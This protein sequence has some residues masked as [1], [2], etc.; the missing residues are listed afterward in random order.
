[1]SIEVHVRLRPQDPTT[2]V[3]STADTVLYNV[4][5]PQTRY[6]FNKVH[7][8][9]NTTNKSVFGGVEPLVLAGFSSLQHVSIMAYGPTGSGKTYSMTGTREDAG[10]I[11]RTAKLLVKLA[12]THPGTL[13]KASFIEVYNECVRDLLDPGRGNGDLPLQDTPD[14]AVR[15]DKKVVSIESVS[16]FLSWQ[17]LAEQHRRYGVTDLNAH[18][19]RSHIMITFEVHRLRRVPVEDDGKRNEEEEEGGNGGEEL[20]RSASTVVHFVH[21]VDLAGAECAGKARTEGQALREGGCINK[22]LL[23][24]GNVVDALVERRSHVPYRDAKLTRLLRSALSGTGG[25]TFILCCIHPGKENVDQTTASLRFTQRAMRLKQDPVMVLPI[26]PLFTHQYANAVE[27]LLEASPQCAQLAYQRG[28]RDA[29]IYCDPTVANLTQQMQDEVGV[30]LHALAGMQRLLVARDHAISLDTIGRWY[31]KLQEVTMQLD[32]VAEQ[33]RSEQE[34]VRRFQ[35]QVQDKEAAIQAEEKALAMVQQKTDITLAEWEVQL[36]QLKQQRVTPLQL[37]LLKEEESRCRVVYEWCVC[38]ERIAN[39]SVEQYPLI[40]ILYQGGEVVEKPQESVG[41]SG[42]KEGEEHSLTAEEKKRNNRPSSFPFSVS[43]P[44][45][46]RENR[47]WEA[48]WQAQVKKERCAV[49]ELEAAKSL[50]HEREMVSMACTSPSE[51]DEKR[52]EGGRRIRTECHAT[53]GHDEEEEEHGAEEKEDRSVSFLPRLTDLDE[54]IDTLELEEKRLQ[55]LVLFNTHRYS[56]RRLRSSLS[57]YSLSFASETTP[58]GGGGSS[59]TAELQLP[60][61]VRR[62]MEGEVGSGREREGTPES[63]AISPVS[64]LPSPIASSFDRTRMPSRG[65]EQ[66]SEGTKGMWTRQTAPLL[67]V[68][69]STSSLHTTTRVEDG[70]AR[71]G[72][73]LIPSSPSA[74]TVTAAATSS[75]S[76]VL[77]VDSNPALTATPQEASTEAT[78]TILLPASRRISSPSPLP[79]SHPSR[80]KEREE[81][82]ITHRPV[83]LQRSSPCPSYRCPSAVTGVMAENS[84][85]GAMSSFQRRSP[86][87][88]TRQRS[89]SNSSSQGSRSPEGYLTP[90]MMRKKMARECDENSNLDS[91]VESSGRQKKRSM[92]SSRLDRVRRAPTSTDGATRKGGYSLVGSSP[93]SSYTSSSSSSVLHAQGLRTAT[94]T[95]QLIQELKSS[96]SQHTS[97]LARIGGASSSATPPPFSSSGAALSPGNTLRTPIHLHR[98]RSNSHSRSQL[99]P[100]N[101]EGGHGTSPFHLPCT[102]E[103]APS[104]GASSRRGVQRSGSSH[105]YRSNSN[106]TASAYGSSGP[107]WNSSTSVTGYSMPVSPGTPSPTSSFGNPFLSSYSA[108][109]LLR[110]E[111]EYVVSSVSKATTNGIPSTLNNIRS[112]TPQRRSGSSSSSSSTT[113]SILTRPPNHTR[114]PGM[115]ASQKSGTRCQEEEGRTTSYGNRSVNQTEWKRREKSVERVPREHEEKRPGYRRD[116]SQPSTARPQESLFGKGE[117]TVPK[118]TLSSYRSASPVSLGNENILMDPTDGV[119]EV[120]DRTPDAAAPCPGRMPLPPAHGRSSGHRSADVQRSPHYMTNTAMGGRGN[121]RVLNMSK[122]ITS[123]SNTPMKSEGGSSPLVK[124]AVNG[125]ARALWPSRSPSNS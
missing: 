42:G 23:A 94:H 71:D 77:P 110:R 104:P 68:S 36:H 39:E 103:E 55:R 1:M 53:E 84:I 7:P 4:A 11:I 43:L 101:E 125:I 59:Q 27:S 10:I 85:T 79:Y 76:G 61:T 16:D 114:L 99:F 111:G 41:G 25:Y 26:P 124:A 49:V 8:L 14:G 90:M 120:S 92:S 34:K 74:A 38:I 108:P 89:A 62:R 95:L 91:T 78:R 97:S 51:E 63:H 46:W 98:R 32:H 109:P 87:I 80:A 73:P 12:S 20:G 48:E 113:T 57:D 6:V 119:V 50:L 69:S 117:C 66:G 75:P 67:K 100:T 21:L 121:T 24:L 28:L 102:S 44:V 72:T 107:S 52:R 29:F 112:A 115:S 105:H 22:S 86:I 58:G 123:S 116:T 33:H 83:E 118:R 60:A 64:P 45:D 56:L 9:Q 2:V 17:Q 96:I 65:E 81:R 54:R 37:L 122:I 88:K 18:S 19:S 30:T 82:T 31:G 5:Q 70:K 47:A 13:L 93:P 40:A 3:W 106:P 15:L 35:Q